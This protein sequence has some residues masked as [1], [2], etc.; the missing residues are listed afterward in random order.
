MQSS[1]SHEGSLHYDLTLEGIS[2][3][4]IE[5]TRKRNKMLGAEKR[6]EMG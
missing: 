4:A 1:F 3:L 2:V 5:P 6:L